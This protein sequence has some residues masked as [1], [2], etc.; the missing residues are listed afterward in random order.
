[1]R[2]EKKKYKKKN[3]RRKTITK[4]KYCRSETVDAKS[5]EESQSP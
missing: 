4:E 2:Q 3:K 1:M 5:R